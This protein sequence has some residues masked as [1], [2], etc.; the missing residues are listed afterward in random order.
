MLKYHFT[1][2]YFIKVEYIVNN[3]EQVIGGKFEYL[4]VVLLIGP[5]VAHNHQVAHANNSI[6]GR[7]DLV[8]HGGKKLGFYL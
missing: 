6:K 1:G 8:R 5:W 4:Q 3:S 7:P 2:F